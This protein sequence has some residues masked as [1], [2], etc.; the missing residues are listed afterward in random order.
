MSYWAAIQKCSV[1]PFEIRNYLPEKMR[2]LF[3]NSKLSDLGAKLA[4]IP[5]EQERDIVC[6]SLLEKVQ[7]SVPTIKSEQRFVLNTIAWAFESGFI[8]PTAYHT[9][10]WA[11]ATLHSV[12]VPALHA[13]VSL[14]VPTSFLYLS[15]TST[16]IIFLLLVSHRRSGTYIL[17][18]ANKTFPELQNR[19]S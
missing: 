8:L 4:P 18:K 10:F 19:E 5:I 2:S 3:S 14:I 7:S 1:Y 9:I 17:T 12:H 16:S 15:F 13:T 6:H 11:S